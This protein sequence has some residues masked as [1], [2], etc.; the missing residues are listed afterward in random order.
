[1]EI[2]FTVTLPVIKVVPVGIGSV[3]T[4][5]LTVSIPRFETTMVYKM[6][7]PTIASTASVLFTTLT[8]GADTGMTK[9]LD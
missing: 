3:S 8:L 5:L 9:I 4:T 2:V 7:S 1:M 6:V